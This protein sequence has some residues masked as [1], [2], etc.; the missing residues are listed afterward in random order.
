LVAGGDCRSLTTFLKLEDYL[1]PLPLPALMALLMVLGCLYLGRRLG[2]ALLPEPP[3][4]LHSAAGFILAASLMA[5]AVNFLALVGLAYYWPLRIMAW[6][7]MRCLV[8]GGRVCPNLA[9]N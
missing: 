9:K 3:K 6:G 7:A 1:A 5:A 4:P 8:S 2:R